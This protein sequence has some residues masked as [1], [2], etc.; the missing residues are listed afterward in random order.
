VTSELHSAV[1]IA[2]FFDLD[3]TLLAEP[4][5]E[6][7][8]FSALRADHKIP[9]ANYFHWSL[10]AIRLLPKGILAL[11]HNNK[12]Y[13]AGLSRD[14]VFRYMESISFFEEA[15]VRV[16][17]HARQGHR[18]VLV[19]GTLE[20]LAQLAASALECE[21]EIRSF[22]LRCHAC[23]TRLG[24]VHG[25]WSG[26]VDGRS[27]YGRSKA[28]T[29]ETFAKRERLDL[30]YCHAYGN[31][32]L[33]RPFLSSVGHAHA[34][35]PSRELATIANQNDWPIWNWH[36][37]KQVVSNEAADLNESIHHRGRPA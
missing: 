10:E 8:F 9:L 22:P 13:L 24:E 7:R 23:A 4:S 2:A 14:L 37:Q 18:I 6:W 19:S 31:S 20:P 36:H 21:L 26:K 35:N 12:K 30:R 1:G 29:V 16:A 3:G 25:C 17:W 33:D 15:I 11:Q 32:L 27:I 28:A 5:L 34:V